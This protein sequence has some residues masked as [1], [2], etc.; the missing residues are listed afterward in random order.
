MENTNSIKVLST[1]LCELIK[2]EAYTASTITAMKSVLNR[3]S[4]YMDR[5]NLIEYTPEV[6]ERF[7]A[8]R[9]SQHVCSSLISRTKSITEKLNRLLH[10]K[11]GKDALLSDNSKEFDF[12]DGIMKPLTDY[13]AHC[14]EKGNKQSTIHAK[15]LVCGNFLKNLSD[16]GCTEIRDVTAKHVQTAFLTMGFIRYW[17]RVGPFLRFLFDNNLIEQN[18]SGL[19]QHRRRPMPMPTVYSAEEIACVENS[20]DLSSPGGIRNHAILLLMTRYGIRACDVAALTFDDID[21]DNN[22]LRFIQQKTGDPWEGELFPKVKTALQNYMENVRP[23]FM[24]CR[25]VFITLTPPYVPINNS[26]VNTMTWSQFQ[27]AEFDR[28][29]RR[30]GSRAFRS[31]V[32]SN[33]INDGVSTEI[34]RKVLGHGTKH[35]L[36]HYARIDIESMRLC[37]LPVPEPSGAFAEILSGKEA[38]PCV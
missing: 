15:Y 26:V 22:R 16:L 7:I 5:N 25:N 1:Q 31:S 4:S 35:A 3:L 30:R 10:G 36:R 23:Q 34:V 20:L 21:F 14:A 37:P 18:Y 33:M 28:A 32:A 17:E 29:G 9:I 27:Y 11:D 24:K 12:P 6:G 8:H 19:V 38:F 2:S 13:L